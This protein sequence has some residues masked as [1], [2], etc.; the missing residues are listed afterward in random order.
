MWKQ[1]GNASFYQVEGLGSVSAR[2]HYA[3][4]LTDS[5]RSREVCSQTFE[6]AAME[7]QLLTCW[8]FT[9][10]LIV[11]KWFPAARINSQSKGWKTEGGNIATH[12]WKISKS[13]FNSH[14]QNKKRRRI[15]SNVICVQTVR[16][17]YLILQPCSKEDE[18]QAELDLKRICVHSLILHRS[19][20]GQRQD[21]D[22]GY[23]SNYDYKDFGG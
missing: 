7:V 22:H 14:F 23:C 21:G 15:F 1:R 11:Y 12:Y 13:P 5:V 2:A 16:F 9:S 18:W 8:Q 3:D 20:E 4:W 19:D 17:Y 6:N 10:C